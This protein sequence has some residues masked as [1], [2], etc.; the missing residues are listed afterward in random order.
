[1]HATTIWDQRSFIYTAVIIN[2]SERMSKGEGGKR[3][4]KKGGRRMVIL[5]TRILSI[6][7]LTG[8]WSAIT[9]PVERLVDIKGKGR[10]RGG[11]KA[12]LKLNFDMAEAESELLQDFIQNIQKK[13][14]KGEKK[15]KKKKRGE[16]EGDAIHLVAANFNHIGYFHL[17]NLVPGKTIFSIF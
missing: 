10:R 2:L 5:R 13:G 15:K 11:K 12:L 4:G 3:K 1:L 7:V 17:Q 6:I 8:A 14:G 16:R 9:H